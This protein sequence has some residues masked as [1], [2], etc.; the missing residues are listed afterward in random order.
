MMS[1][2]STAAMNAV[3]RTKAGVASGTLSMSRMV[4]GT[5]GVAVLGALVAAVGRHELDE[6]LPSVPGDGARAAR[7]RA[8]LR[9]G[10]AGAPG[11]RARAPRGGVRRR[12]RHRPD[13]RGDRGRRSPRWSAWF[14]IAAARPRPSRSRPRARPSA[15]AAMVSARHA[16]P[17]PEVDRG[18]DRA[19]CASATSSSGST[20][21]SPSDEDVERLGEALGLHPVALEDTREFGQRP[22]LDHY[23]DHVL[24]VFYTAS[25]PAT[26]VAGRAARGPHLPLRRLHGHRPPRARA[27]RARRAAREARAPRRPTTR[28]ML[29]YRR[30]RRADRR[31]LPGDRRDR[32]ARRRARGARCSSARGAS[33]CAASTGSSRAC[34]SCT[35]SSPPSATSSPTARDAIL[36]ARRALDGRS[37]QYLRDIGDHLVPGRRRA[38]APERGPDRRSRQTYFN[39]NA[40]RLNRDRHAADR[41]RHVLRRSG[42][43]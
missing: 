37:R 19:R 42:R 7:R 33:S 34:T 25:R 16:R 28:S 23:G 13:D 24:I 35:G 30:P 29:V 39:A 41:R 22:K 11:Q 10:R 40:N 15:E 12:A 5:F 43:S 9:R 17:R 21:S 1:P 31:L 14:L 20:S 36:G 4:G 26:R 3:D 32:G 2:M 6:S 8:R 18:R 27:R 38:P